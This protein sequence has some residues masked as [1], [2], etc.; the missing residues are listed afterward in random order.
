MPF[1]QSIR[2]L[3][4]VLVVFL[5]ACATAEDAVQPVRAEASKDPFELIKAEVTGDTLT[6]TV[7]Y[8]GGSAKH[9]F[10]LEPQGAAT[11]SLPRQQMLVLRHNA[12]GDRARALITEERKFPLAAWQDPRNSVVHIRLEGWE[13]VMVY[14]YER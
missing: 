4:A 5:A 12:H 11:K 1:I 3:A 14:R 9:D 10:M 2:G 6:V 8:S 7:Q 13:E